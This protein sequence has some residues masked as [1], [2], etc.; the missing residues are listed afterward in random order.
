MNRGHCF[1]LKRFYSKCL[2]TLAK[3]SQIFSISRHL[4]GLCL[5]G[6]AEA[7]LPKKKKIVIMVSLLSFY[8]Y[9]LSE[10]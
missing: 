3:F 9:R 8:R 10:I 5:Q 4:N 7:V 1:L 6:S 2:N